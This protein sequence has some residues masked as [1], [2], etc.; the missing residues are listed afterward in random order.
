MFIANKQ[1]P[2]LCCSLLCCFDFNQSFN[3][4]F[5]YLYGKEYTNFKI[6]MVEISNLKG[7]ILCK[8]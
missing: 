8:V 5:W 6:R 1:V 4:L 2:V 7:T 3:L